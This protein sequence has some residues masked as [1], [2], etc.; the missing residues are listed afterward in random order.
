MLPFVKIYNEFSPKCCL[1]CGGRLEF[2]ESL[3]CLKCKHHIPKTGFLAQLENPVSELF[4]GR[5]YLQQ[6][7]SMYYFQKKS[8]LQAMLHA[9]KYKNKPEMGQLLGEMV[10]EEMQ[11]YQNWRHFDAIVPVPLHPDKQ[12]IRGYNQAEEIAK[13][14]QKKIF[15]P[16]V[17]DIV[18]RTKF[19][20][21]QT[22]KTKI[23]RWHNMQSVF[24]LNEKANQFENKHL[25]IIDD[26][27]TTG[28]TIDATANVL[29]E[30]KDVKLSVLTVAF[31]K[32]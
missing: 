30:I 2:F 27:L 12:K 32:D 1:A 28:A 9:L 22:R 24:G 14:I 23:E 21:S 26:V 20:E 25:L 13:G 7:A 11:Q 18:Y 10:A 8:R 3:I 17:S 16:I 19:T 15:I 31:A 29:S 6:A 4:W 5:V